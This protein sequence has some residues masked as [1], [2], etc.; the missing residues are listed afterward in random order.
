[1][2]AREAQAILLLHRPG[3]P[4]DGDPQMAA[5]LALARRDPELAAWFTQHCAFQEALR[6]KL[7]SAPVPAD[8][9]EQLLAAPKII[10]PVFWQRRS[11]WLAAAA[12]LVLLLGLAG[13][14]LRQP[15][16]DRF[17]DFRSR[18]VRTVLREYRMDI[19]TNDM[20]QVRHFMAT[21]GAPADY[22]VPAGLAQL[23]LT[24]GGQLQ[25]RGHP[26]S[27]VCFDRGNQQMLYLFVLPRAATKS[28]PPSVPQ[29]ERVNKL[30]TL[31]WSR[32]DKV[33]LLAGPEE[34]D[35]AGKYF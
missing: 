32:G 5:A 2:T 31:S 33:Y 35:F 28:V 22:E 26:V 14:W 11:N 15:P 16:P 25:W 20:A 7:A 3:L 8:L 10:R 9:R 12:V 21:R 4:D 18:M 17:A 30:Q 24:G 19:V 34:D 6:R 13:I 27:M 29:A 1:M 23:P